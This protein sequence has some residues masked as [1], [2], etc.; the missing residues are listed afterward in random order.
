MKPSSIRV[1]ATCIIFVLASVFNGAFAAEAKKPGRKAEEADKFLASSNIP[2]IQIEIA[3]EDMKK[4]RKYTWQFGP[5]GDRE[6]VKVTVRE[7]GTTYTN[8]ALQLKGAAG[9]FRPIDDNPALTLNFDKF[10]DNQTFHGLDKLSLNNSVQDQTYVSEQFARELFLKAGVPTPRATHATVELNGRDLGLYVLVE[11]WNRRFLKKHFADPSG[12]LYDGGFLKDVDSE[13][14]TNSGDKPED[15]AD[16]E[17]L[18]KAAQ[19]K[20]LSTRRERLEKILDMDRFLT[21]VALDTMLWNW[22][23]YAQN[24]NNYRLFSDRTTGKMVFMPH[25]LDQLFWKPDGSVLPNMQGLVARAVLEVPELREKYLA[26]LKELRS[27]VFKPG[28]MTNRVHQIAA[29]IAPA[30]KEKDPSAASQQEFSVTS[31]A[32]AIVRRASSID[33]QLKTPIAPI[34]FDDSSK[35]TITTWT[36]KTN[37]GKAEL[38]QD[39][40]ILKTSTTQGSSIGT[41]RSAAWLE[42]GK[43]RLEASVK[44]HGIVADPG[45]SRAGAGLRVGRSRSEKYLT[46]T[47]DWTPLSQE[48]TVEEALTQI[49]FL[50]EFRGAEGEASFRSIQLTKLTEK[51]E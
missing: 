42:R 24:K 44:T 6:Q 50:C 31:L 8:V 25:G 38:T 16:R 45:D 19:E 3:P 32:H 39:G 4:L 29:K 1:R 41:W 43:Y 7:G 11:G 26:R 46:A 2:N 5:Q 28:E 23:G 18:A 27:T 37:F 34:K 17:A 33:E 49:Q 14:S 30:L 40:N 35:A 20:N 12:N 47:S 36:P 13:L 10:V 9:S 21:F 48:F 51:A 15:Q 22:D